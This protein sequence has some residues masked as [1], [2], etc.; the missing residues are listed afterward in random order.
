MCPGRAPPSDEI[1]MTLRASSLGP[2]S[3]APGSGVAQWRQIA[4][5]LR[6]DIAGGALKPG[7]Q[8]LT[9]AG[10]A[11]RFGV[12]RH[13]V[14]RALEELSRAGAIRIEQGR[15]SFVAE[16]VL[17]Y[18]VGARTRF[19][20]WIRRHNRE[21]SGRV[22]ALRGMPAPLA[23]ADGLSIREGEPVVVLE[24]VGLAD[25]RPV[26]LTSHHFPASRLPGIQDALRQESSI[27]AALARVGVADYLRQSTRVSAR[28]PLGFE[29]AALAMARG[30]P[31]LV[32][33]NVNV[34]RTGR[35]VEFG[36]A[37]YPT[38]RVQIVFE[39]EEPA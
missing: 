36:I 22:L 15:G 17:D 10:L 5:R 16:D 25:G 24:R 20:E 4:D 2:D 34:D 1:A 32:C 6:A 28:L 38:P 19:S 11:V 21:P 13:T 3:L 30:L 35:I 37:R 12:N 14:R 8:L 7:D 27:T 39:P 31:L 33:E 26:S 29:A 18:V 9:E 23:I